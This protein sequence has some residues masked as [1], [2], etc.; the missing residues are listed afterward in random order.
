MPTFGMGPGAESRI[1]RRPGGIRPKSNEWLGVVLAGS[2][3]GTPG[4]ARHLDAERTCKRPQAT[5][6]PPA[7]QFSFRSRNPRARR[8]GNRQRENP[9]HP[10]NPTRDINARPA[11]ER[12][13]LRPNSPP[14]NTATLHASANPWSAAL[15]KAHSN[16]GSR[17]PEN[18]H[19]NV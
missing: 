10:Q 6:I 11:S 9:A 2:D 4:R 13:S 7:S 3:S 1:A 17:E 15:L 16:R 18:T 19:L 12:H 5:Q 8:P 14:E